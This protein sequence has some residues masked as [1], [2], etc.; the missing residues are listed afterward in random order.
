MPDKSQCFANR[1]FHIFNWGS[2]NSVVNFTIDELRFF[3]S[4]LSKF[5][6]N[7]SSKKPSLIDSANALLKAELPAN[8]DKLT[9]IEVLFAGAVKLL[10]FV[11]FTIIERDF[12]QND[13]GGFTDDFWMWTFELFALAIVDAIIFV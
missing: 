4:K 6:K 7:F 9:F 8:K 11:L 5:F 3:D 1:L 2:A 13:I 12:R 10:N